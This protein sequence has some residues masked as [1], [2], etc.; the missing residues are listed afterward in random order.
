MDSNGMIPA[1]PTP[2]EYNVDKRTNIIKARAKAAKLLL[3]GKDIPPPV[4]EEQLTLGRHLSTRY[5]PTQQPFSSLSC[6]KFLRVEHVKFFAEVFNTYNV[7]PSTEMSPFMELVSEEKVAENEAPPSTGSSSQLPGG[8]GVGGGAISSA[9]ISPSSFPS[10]PSKSNISSDPVE[11]SQPCQGISD[12][13]PRPKKK[14]NVG[15]NMTELSA[16]LSR[17][18]PGDLA[19][20]REWFVECILCIV[21]QEMEAAAALAVP[22]SPTAAADQDGA[23]RCSSRRRHSSSVVCS[24]RSASF[25]DA[26]SELGETSEED[27][28]RGSVRSSRTGSFGTRAPS[29]ASIASSHEEEQE[30]SEDTNTGRQPKIKKRRKLLS[31]SFS[32]LLRRQEEGDGGGGVTRHRMVSVNTTTPAP[33]SDTTEGSRAT[34]VD[35]IRKGAP[36][37]ESEA[38]SLEGPTV[39]ASSAEPSEGGGLLGALFGDGTR[40]QPP[41][42]LSVGELPVGAPLPVAPLSPSS[43]TKGEEK[44]KEEK[45]P[46]LHQAFGAPNIMVP[47]VVG[48]DGGASQSEAMGNV[49]NTRKKEVKVEG[50]SQYSIPLRKRSPGSKLEST[51]ETGMSSTAA[52]TLGDP[53]SSSDQMSSG[54]P[55]PIAETLAGNFS[56]GPT[57]GASLPSAAPQMESVA[58]GFRTVLLPEPAEKKKKKGKRVEGGERREKKSGKGEEKSIQQKSSF[59]GRREKKGGREGMLAGEKEGRPGEEEVVESTMFSAPLEGIS[60]SDARRRA[61]EDE[62]RRYRQELLEWL[63]PL[64]HPLDGHHVPSLTEACVLQVQLLERFHA[65]GR[66]TIMRGKRGNQLFMNNANL[67]MFNNCGVLMD[68]ANQSM[69]THRSASLNGASLQQQGGGAMGQGISRFRNAAG[70]IKSFLKGGL[71]RGMDEDGTRFGDRPPWWRKGSTAGGEFLGGHGGVGQTSS[72]GRRRKSSAVDPQAAFIQE[73]FMANSAISSVRATG[74]GQVE[75]QLPPA[76]PP[77]FFQLEAKLKEA[78]IMKEFVNVSSQY[79]VPLVTRNTE[80]LQEEKLTSMVFFGENADGK[81]NQKYSPHWA[82]LVKNAECISILAQIH[83]ERP[84]S[85]PQGKRRKLKEGYFI[86]CW[87][88]ITNNLIMDFEQNQVSSTSELS[89]TRV[90]TMMLEEENSKKHLLALQGVPRGIEGIGLNLRGQDTNHQL[91][92]EVLEDEDDEEGKDSVMGAGTTSR[93]LRGLGHKQKTVNM[94][95]SVQADLETFSEELKGLHTQSA[96]K[97]LIATSQPSIITSSKDGVIKVWETRYGHFNTNLLNVGTAWVLGMWLLHD[98]QYMLVSTSNAELTI[99]EY[100]KGA[101]LQK[102]RGCTSLI[103]AMRQV[104]QR[105]ATVIHR[106]G[107]RPGECGPHRTDFKKDMAPD[108]YKM[109]F[110]EAQIVSDHTIH[111]AKPIEG[112]VAPSAVYFDP[113]QGGMFFFGNSEGV[114]GYFDLT[115]EVKQ[116]TILSGA[117]N[118][119]IFI[120]SFV[121][122]HNAG[123]RVVGV[124]FVSSSSYLISVGEDGSVV[125]TMF[126]KTPDLRHVSSSAPL[127]STAEGGNYLGVLSDPQTLIIVPRPV[128]L[129]E[130]CVSHRMFATAHSDR[131]VVLWSL[132]R[133][134]AEFVHQFPAETQDIIS[135]TFLAHENHIA[136]LTADRCIRI[137]DFRGMRPLAVIYPS[138]FA[139]N[140]A[141]DVASVTLKC[142]KDDPDGCL[143]YLPDTRRLVCALRAPV[144]YEPTKAPLASEDCS[145]GPEREKKSGRR[146]S[147]SPSPSA[148]SNIPLHI[149]TTA[150][151]KAGLPLIQPEDSDEFMMELEGSTSSSSSSSSDVHSG[152]GDTKRSSGDRKTKRDERE[153]NRLAL[154]RE[155]GER[156]LEKKRL[157]PHTTLTHSAIAV[158]IHFPSAVVHTFSP[159]QWKSWDI[160]T[161]NLIREVDVSDKIRNEMRMFKCIRITSCGW[162]TELRTRLLAGARNG[163]CVTLDATTGAVVEVDKLLTETRL[164]GE[165]LDRD[166]SSVFHVK[167]RTFICSGRTI[168]VRRYSTGAVRPSGEELFSSITLRIPVRTTITACCVIRGSHLCVGT[169]DTKLYFFR[170]IDLS[171][172]YHEEVL[173][174]SAV[175]GGGGPSSQ[176]LPSSASSAQFLGSPGLSSATAIQPDIPSSHTQQPYNC[177][178][179]ISSVV[180][181]MFVN[182]LNQ[183]LLFIVLDNGV[184]FVYSTLRACLL[185][186][187]RVLKPA[188]ARARCFTHLRNDNLILLGTTIGN[189]VGLDLS[190]CTSAE[191]DFKQAIRV[192]VCFAAGTSEITGIDTL[193]V[194]QRAVERIVQRRQSRISVWG[195]V[196]GGS[197]VDFSSTIAS[198]NATNVSNIAD[199]TLFMQSLRRDEGKNLL[200]QNRPPLVPANL[201]VGEAGA[202]T[203]SGNSVGRAGEDRG[204]SGGKIVTPRFAEKTLRDEAFLPF[205]GKLQPHSPVVSSPL[206]PTSRYVVVSSIDGNVR[207]FSLEP[208][209]ATSP[210]EGGEPGSCRASASGTPSPQYPPPHFG[211]PSSPAVGRGMSEGGSNAAVAVAQ[212]Y[213]TSPRGGK[214]AAAKGEGVRSPAGMGHPPLH[215]VFSHGMLNSSFDA[216]TLGNSL[217]PSPRAP[218][219]V[220]GR[221]TPPFTNVISPRLPQMGNHKANGAQLGPQGSGKMGGSGTTF[222]VSAPLADPYDGDKTGRERSLEPGAVRSISSGTQH[223]QETGTGGSGRSSPAIPT[224]SHSCGHSRVPL[225]FN[226][227]TSGQFPPNHPTLSS[228]FGKDGLEGQRPRHPSQNLD[229]N[230]LSFLQ[231]G[232]VTPYIESFHGIMHSCRTVGL[233]G[234]DHWDLLQPSSFAGNPIPPFQPKLMHA[235]GEAF[236]DDILLQGK[237]K[238]EHA[239]KNGW[240]ST[241]ESVANVGI[242]GTTSTV[243]GAGGKH[244]ALPGAGNASLTASPSSPHLSGAGAGPALAVA[245]GSDSNA[246]PSTPEGM[247]PSVSALPGGFLADGT[248][249]TSIPSTFGNTNGSHLMKTMGDTGTHGGSPTLTATG[250]AGGVGSGKKKGSGRR[251]GSGAISGRSRGPSER[252]KTSISPG[253]SSRKGRKRNTGQGTIKQAGAAETRSSAEGREMEMNPNAMRVA[254]VRE[255]AE[256][257]LL[258]EREF[259]LNFCR[260]VRKASLRPGRGKRSIVGNNGSGGTRTKKNDLPSRKKLQAGMPSNMSFERKKNAT[261]VISNFATEWVE[262]G[263]SPLLNLP[264]SLSPHTGIGNDLH[265]ISSPNHAAGRSIASILPHGTRESVTEVTEEQKKTFISSLGPQRRY[266]K[267]K[268]Q[269]NPLLR[270]Y[271]VKWAQ[272]AL[273][274]SDHRSP[275]DNSWIHELETDESGNL[276]SGEFSSRQPSGFPVEAGG[277]G[278]AVLPGGS[279]SLSP[280]AT[281]ASPPRPGGREMEH[282]SQRMSYQQDVPSPRIGLSTGKTLPS[283]HLGV[284]PS[285]TFPVRD[286]PTSVGSSP[287]SRHSTP[288]TPTFPRRLSVNAGTSSRG[289][290][291][292]TAASEPPRP[293]TQKGHLMDLQSPVSADEQKGDGKAMGWVPPSSPV[294]TQ[295]PN[296][297]SVLSTSSGTTSRGMEMRQ[298]E[299]PPSRRDSSKFFITSL[300]EVERK[301]S[302][303]VGGMPKA[304]PEEGPSTA[305]GSALL[306]FQRVK[307]RSFPAADTPSL[308]SSGN[309]LQRARTFQREE[310]KTGGG[311][312][313]RNRS[314]SRSGS[315]SSGHTGHWGVKAPNG[316][317][318]T[319]SVRP[320]FHSSA[321]VSRYSTDMMDAIPSMHDP[322]QVNSIEEKALGDTQG[323]LLRAS[324]NSRLQSTTTPANFSPMAPQ[325]VSALGPQEE[326]GRGTASVGTAPA[327]GRAGQA[328][329]DLG[330]SIGRATV[331]FSG[332]SHPG[333]MLTPSSSTGPRTTDG[334]LHGF[335]GFHTRISTP[336]SMIGGAP[337]DG[338]GGVGPSTVCFP[339]TGT[340]ASSYSAWPGSSGGV[341]AEMTT[342]DEG[343]AGGRGGNVYEMLRDLPKEVLEQRRDQLMLAFMAQRLD[344]IRPE[345]PDRHSYL[346]DVKRVWVRRVGEAQVVAETRAAVLAATNSGSNTGSGGG[347]EPPKPHGGVRHHPGIAHLTNVMNQEL[348]KS[349]AGNRVELNLNLLTIPTEERSAQEAN[350]QLS[351]R[352]R[353]KVQLK[354]LEKQRKEKAEER[355]QLEDRNP[356][357]RDKRYWLPLISSKQPTHP[358][359]ITLPSTLRSDEGARHQLRQ[360]HQLVAQPPPRTMSTGMEAHH[361]RRK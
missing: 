113:T 212:P 305:L 128:R 204:P 278:M 29:I 243:A 213:F 252:E 306:P 325:R 196:M 294:T 50:A 233:F 225:N 267:Q 286:A 266:N 312:G 125:R 28:E 46:A 61:K 112:Y 182:D 27:E 71:E 85:Y 260:G 139:D 74:V 215:P 296:T 207:L 295:Q 34:E 222:P 35:D 206:Y 220:S 6:A 15:E 92:K 87:S 309:F 81:R 25:S 99:L 93:R 358:I 330:A 170:L 269:R 333:G 171:G 201:K 248:F 132:T 41:V 168:I 244:G 195:S 136:F 77:V 158:I 20:S 348:Q 37:Y 346:D 208:P 152:L 94:P 163:H 218:V 127:P 258:H 143:G 277:S 90:Q 63:K 347:G 352:E 32:F 246:D 219:P 299:P 338:G 187:I 14:Q 265:P 283:S 287:S 30:K 60:A 57:G 110:R 151:F 253:T 335:S 4:Q 359:R 8:G 263:G 129:L 11:G 245:S 33:S 91:N 191:V 285:H 42:L 230:R 324:V 116:S 104:A 114:V 344:K 167:N 135:I 78:P 341:G 137:Y 84:I 342:A 289:S 48:S 58:A 318:V 349:E 155:L 165:P 64:C 268:F 124:V 221:G 240:T 247:R 157:R 190:Q 280:T 43:G 216:I 241:L 70:M 120:R 175:G 10:L 103:S 334:N 336:V 228:S 86:L 117:N 47:L 321:V 22:T 118:H 52:T 162:T 12:S 302:L 16:D 279:S 53:Y 297:K 54:F 189:V 44:P 79:V 55:L 339:G 133:Y 209:S 250:V 140:N 188:V 56:E 82:D 26:G 329:V 23:S 198:L 150:S 231:V 97:V 39:A 145:K 313:S 300:G 319:G 18:T 284:L 159:R 38:L 17:F 274:M 119:P 199:S 256:L 345:G 24:T 101:I 172:P 217:P 355:R 251:D 95:T 340:G 134:G 102:F 261:N 62:L 308:L 315:G 360:L 89:Y 237:R 100:P 193:T 45:P 281:L 255:E 7:I 271:P 200:T 326:G 211:S 36:S 13:I 327:P 138:R 317:T 72:G 316:T 354:E 236:L 226:I 234:C 179:E 154:Q 1:M 275:A 224:P 223:L 272:K 40:R 232:A 331:T 126:T 51:M 98:D 356:N 343:N 75:T 176:G 205:S 322:S 146:G 186:R 314:F 361:P 66:Q 291:S 310:K 351:A 115:Q 270:T 144:M 169:I 350:A 328:E 105:G 332:S 148:T 31:E 257:E 68:P 164:R 194:S 153:A 9:T 161:G 282:H 298:E 177:E 197:D 83:R 142:S 304:P 264:F 192:T 141:E 203:T 174:R 121:H 156:R 242:S 80:C 262:E 147:K 210:I 111:V 109:L 131:R 337:L 184:L 288:G 181:I 273:K 166:I 96:D 320:P 65:A 149:V 2:L 183:N 69:R 357:P 76:P 108:D 178:P 130:Y 122:A 73:L 3:E 229:L 292:P 185:A 173:Y 180:G 303:L 290:S 67:S 19:I 301:S 254:K 107:L 5:V 49:K 88:D 160:L 307:R 106:Y 353:L 323:S 259:K 123:V 214:Q 293:Q 249:L 59:V 202:T 311:G 21:A 227:N 239:E 238:M 276:P 235:M